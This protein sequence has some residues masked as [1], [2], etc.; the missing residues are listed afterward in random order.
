MVSPAATTSPVFRILSACGQRSR[1]WKDVKVPPLDLMGFDLPWDILAALD[2]G[3]RIHYGGAY[4]P[5]N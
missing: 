1:R 3:M 5:R 4:S 2:R